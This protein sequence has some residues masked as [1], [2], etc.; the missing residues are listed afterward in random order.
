MKNTLLACI[1]AYVES[2]KSFLKESTYARYRNLIDNYVKSSIGLTDLEDFNNRSLQYYCDSLIKDKVSLTVIKE[3]VLLIKLSL[4]KEAKLNGSTPPY[5]DL[6]LPLERKNKKIQFLNKVEQKQLITYICESKKQKYIGVFLALMTGLRIGEICALKWK[7]ID[8]KKRV[9][10]VN[11]TLQRVCYK[12][13]KSK[14]LIDEPKTRNS[15]REI[16]INN[17]LYE[18]LLEARPTNRE[19]YVLTYSMTPTEPRNYRKIFDTLM[20][21]LKLQHISF[22][23]LRHT[24]ATRL[25]ENKVDLKTVSELLGH[26][27]VNITISIYVHSEFKTKRKAVKTLDSILLK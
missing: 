24:F 8:L 11:K 27:S 20:R 26:S 15:Q 6:D 9:V 25:I 3:I 7:D 21:K 19:L 13:Q 18:Y 23:A 14:I 12:G 1:L 10:I 2:R 5:I 4:R 22:H 17:I 16:P